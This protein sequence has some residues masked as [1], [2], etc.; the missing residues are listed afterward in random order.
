MLA[1][2]SACGSGSCAKT[3]SAIADTIASA[4]R[5]AVIFFFCMFRSFLLINGRTR[6][7]SGCTRQPV[8]VYLKTKKM[9]DISQTQAGFK[10]KSRRNPLWI[11]RL[12]NAKS[13]CVCRNRLYFRLFRYTL[14]PRIAFFIKCGRAEKSTINRNFIYYTTHQKIP[15]HFYHFR[16]VKIQ[17]E[18][19]GFLPG[20]S[21]S[22]N[23]YPVR[24][25]GAQWA[26]QRVRGRLNGG[27][28]LCSAL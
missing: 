12:F 13:R 1:A 26:F 24:L 3:G 10:A 17:G 11:P 18:F 25:A 22:K 7:F 15:Q 8:K 14:R 27:S 5:N 9:T 6:G 2:V 20:L 28:A 23:R 19:L 4:S 21:F 16:I